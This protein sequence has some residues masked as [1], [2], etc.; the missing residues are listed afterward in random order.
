MPLL[1]H[2]RAGALVHGGGGRAFFSPYRFPRRFDRRSWCPVALRATGPIVR[3]EQR[4]EIGRPLPT[5][6]MSSAALDVGALLEL[7]EMA[8]EPPLGQSAA[9]SQALLP[10]PALAI[11]V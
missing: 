7:V 4:V 8:P 11:I 10:W 9:A 1:H 6:T 3:Y 2:L 5:G